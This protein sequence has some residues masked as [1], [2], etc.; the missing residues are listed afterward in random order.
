VIRSQTS[1]RQWQ[2]TSDETNQT[3][4]RNGFSGCNLER[5]TLNV[6]RLFVRDRLPPVVVFVGWVQVLPWTSVRRRND[7]HFSR[8]L[9]QE[10]HGREPRIMLV[11]LAL[12]TTATDVIRQYYDAPAVTC[13]AGRVTWR[14][15]TILWSCGDHR[16]NPFWLGSQIGWTPS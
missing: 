4:Q 6:E 11:F 1:A 10:C 7:C 12:W 15:G 9:Q 14:T 8:H 3:N 13:E 5:R 2:V 16:G